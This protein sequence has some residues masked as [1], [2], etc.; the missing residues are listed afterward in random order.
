MR[1]FFFRS[2]QIFLCRFPPAEAN[3]R[4]IL[5]P[6]NARQT[7]KF[8][9]ISAARNMTALPTRHAHATRGPSPQTHLTARGAW[10]SASYARACVTPYSQPILALL[11]ALTV[12]AP[13]RGVAVLV[14]I[15]GSERRLDQPGA[16]GAEAV[17]RLPHLRLHTD[18]ASLS[19]SAAC[20]ACGWPVCKHSCSRRVLM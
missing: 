13:R 9:H 4:Q 17:L 19:R 18:A 12:R 1:G 7:R 20:G 15:P 3:F 16:V 14:A 10:H 6:E 11:L 2:P 5:R 8:S